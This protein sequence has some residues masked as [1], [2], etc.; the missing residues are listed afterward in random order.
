MKSILTK[1]WVLFLILISLCSAPAL[2]TQRYVSP[3]GDDNNDGLSTS[4]P[5]QTINKVN[6]FLFQGGDTVSF[7][8]GAT[9]AGCLVFNSTN[10]MNS[11]AATPFTVNSYGTGV[12]TIQSNCTGNTSA[13]VTIDNISGFYFD[14]L[15][16]TNGF[17]AGASSS[18]AIG[19]LLENQ[20]SNAPTQTIVV[21][22][23][24]VTGFAPPS[25]STAIGGEIIVIGYAMN[26]NNGPLNDVEILNNS[27]HGANVT[28]GDHCGVCGYGDGE[29]ITNVLMQ[30]NTV[31]N[32]GNPA[33]YGALEADGMN[34]ATIQYNL[35]HD[36][37]ANTTTCGGTSG[38][39]SYTS[40]NVT[41]RFN[42]VYNVQPASNTQ[43]K[44]FG[45]AGCDW[46]GIDL[47]GGTSN[48]VVEYNYTHHNAGSGLLAYD[49]NVSSHVWGNNTF[50][51]NVSEND[52]WTGVQGGLMDAVG[53]V[54]HNPLYIYGNTFFDNN[55]TE[56]TLSTS[57]ACFYFGFG[58]GTWAS[59][60]LIKDNICYLNNLDKYGR[61]GQ[62]YYNPYTQ[63]GMTLSNNLYWTDYSSPWW[64]WGGTVYKG[65]AAWVAT[66]LETNP[67]SVNPFLNNPGNGG[68]CTWTP[69]LLTGPQT[70]PQ[71]Y[72]LQSGSPAIGTGV[73]VANN[74]GR[75]YYNNSLTSPPSIGAYSTGNPIGGGGGG[76][77]PPAAPTNV[78][79]SAISV[80][81]VSLSWTEVLNATSYNVYRGTI[82]GFTPSGASLIAAG[83][84]FS[85]YTD[86]GLTHSTTYYYVVEAVNY[87][88]SSGPSNQAS[89]IMPD[90][91]NYYVS[92]TGND[93]NSGTSTST[94]WQ[95][96]N[97]VNTSVF[98]EGAIVSFEGGQ[99][100]A[101]CLVANTTNV[102]NSSA[103]NPFTFQ[104]YGTGMATIQSNC[105]G[106][107][108]SAIT[109]D[110]VNGFTV[111]RLKIANGSQT[112]NGVLLENQHHASPVSTLVVK[113]SEI[114]GFTPVSG[115]TGGG[116]EIFV[117]GYAI[118]GNKGP[119]N[120]VQILNNSLHGASVTSP[121]GPGVAGYGYG[122]NIT[123]VLVQGNTVYNLGMPATNSFGA[124]EADGWNG[125][126]IQ[127]NVVHDIGANVTSCGGTSGIE[128]YTSN[129][130]TIRHNEVYNVQP[131]PSFTAGCDWDAIDLDGGTTNSLV[132][133]N[134]T[135][136]NFGTG[137]YAYTVNPS[138]ST[139]GPNTYRYNISENDGLQGGSNGAFGLAGYPPQNALRVYG[140]TFINTVSA[141]GNTGDPAACLFF[142][143]WNGGG[144]AATGSMIEDNICYMNDP[145]SANNVEFVRTASN[146]ISGITF[147]NNL[148][149]TTSNPEWIWN[150]TTYTTL[151]S[152]EGAG[153][154]SG[155]L[156]GDPLL[157]NPGG[158]GTCSW[159]PSALTGPQP[160]PVAYT[161]RYGSPASGAGVSVSANGG[162]DYYGNTIPSSPSIGAQATSPVPTIT[163][164]TFSDLSVGDFSVVPS[165]YQPVSGL[166]I[167]WNGGGTTTYRYGTYTYDGYQDHTQAGNASAPSIDIGTPTKG[168]G[169]SNTSSLNFSAPVTI[170][171]LYVT[172]YDWWKQDVILT[173][174]TNVNDTTPVVT[175][176]VPYTSI[177][178]HATGTTTGAWVQITGLSG[179]PIRRL[180]ITGTKDSG[181]TQYGGA[182]VDDI[183]INR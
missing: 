62:F 63:T 92:P 139:W 49:P 100:F 4:T 109:G 148:Y 125:G 11:S 110:T 74:G 58:G 102:P 36:I 89:V 65:L 34:G 52:D 97:K 162:S 32:L 103:L 91:V 166:T 57:S 165:N 12:A 64:R 106:T 41:V 46:D 154:D 25:G 95:T 82:S 81:T 172:N 147:Q 151:P 101:G 167:T 171:S 69:S 33:P 127:Y 129:N 177:P 77:T 180:D 29:N 137:I 14:G 170:P 157:N 96:I 5:W 24:E 126:T 105:T 21:K 143:L 13:A 159:T 54:P 133:Y 42:E 83:V 85:P 38:I 104:S 53:S 45:G 84:A 140:N 160:C 59:G 115:V 144:A 150:G 142:G 93:S 68:T 128:A 156:F 161:L 7:Q 121:D 90:Q 122:K 61:N 39:E 164:L 75:D 26:G 163:S 2:A 3:N 158:G 153:V 37:G 20:S 183:T 48:S 130:I 23:S 178:N 136:N 79:A 56:N 169:L 179:Y 73:D 118:N 40:N 131:S 87:A 55:T 71:A 98:P 141:S 176:T 31:Y 174:Y 1:S 146:S 60:S 8:G 173:G 149:Y 51:Y 66:G 9:F 155:S 107:G 10:L 182:L 76:G 111:N 27:L 112:L 18:T 78:S 35:I 134:Y 44:T 117:I 30:G 16:V 86:S 43:A 116:A 19:I 124:L 80:S 181:T 132:E 70:C 6:S 119:L 28:A 67:M 50:R 175:V 114:T 88:G 17:T 113:N 168:S 99:T 15:K 120:D 94:P 123:N 47:D 145:N 152:W 108:S 72:T 138:G 22:N 135:H